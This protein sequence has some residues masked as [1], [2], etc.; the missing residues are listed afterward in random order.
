MIGKGPVLT[1]SCYICP[2]THIL[3]LQLLRKL[4]KSPKVE[5][6]YLSLHNLFLD[7][8][9]TRYYDNNPID[10]LQRGYKSIMQAD[11]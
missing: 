5:S 11:E 4:P 2:L 3:K 8:L 6:L 1:L 7:I 10:K 9:D